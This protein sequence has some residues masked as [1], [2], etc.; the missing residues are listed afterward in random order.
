MNPDRSTSVRSKTDAPDQPCESVHL[1]S[2][3]SRPNRDLRSSA[4]FPPLQRMNTAVLG[5]PRWR[6]SRTPRAQRFLRL[7]FYPNNDSRRGQQYEAMGSELTENGGRNNAGHDKGRFRGG[8][9]S[10]VRNYRHSDDS[11]VLEHER[12]QPPLNSAAQFLF[13]GHQ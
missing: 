9:R 6:H 13:C 7:F 10:A 12:T 4:R 2:N 3:H 11:R 1:C 8:R 5:Y